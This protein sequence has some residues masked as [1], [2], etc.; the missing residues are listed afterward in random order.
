MNADGKAT[1]RL[2]ESQEINDP[3]KAA[4]VK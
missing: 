2:D 3:K 1:E 4:H